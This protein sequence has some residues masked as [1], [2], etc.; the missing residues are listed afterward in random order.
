V[1]L[2]EQVVT[3]LSRLSVVEETLKIEKQI[4][5]EKQLTTIRLEADLMNLKLEEEHLNTL[6]VSC[7][8]ELMQQ[9][10]FEQQNV[11]FV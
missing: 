1:E 7:P 3:E 2:E 4:Y 11:R 10:K 6:L 8:K 9:H 5:D